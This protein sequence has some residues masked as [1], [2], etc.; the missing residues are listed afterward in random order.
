MRQNID[1]SLVQVY[2]KSV[3]LLLTITAGA[4]VAMAFGKAP[5]LDIPSPLFGFA[6]NRVL[7]ALAAA[8]EITVAV[9]ILA[10]RRKEVAAVTAVAWL[11]TLFIGYR[12]ALWGTGFH[13]YCDCLGSL[14]GLIHLSAQ[15]ANWIAL[16]IVAYFFIGS[17]GILLRPLARRRKHE[18]PVS[19]A[20]SEPR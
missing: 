12:L 7:V 11:A 13:G 16:G 18:D 19:S 5:L 15:E 14:P 8:I 10:H 17:Y 4:K 3:V 2:L 6:S 20:A 9:S 1:I